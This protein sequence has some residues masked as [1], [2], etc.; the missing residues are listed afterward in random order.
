MRT[1]G[2]RRPRRDE[3]GKVI[4]LKESPVCAVT[5]EE[6][7][8]AF[9]SD[10]DKRLVVSLERGDRIVLRPAR[11]ARPVEITA[12]DLYRHLLLCKANHAQLERARAR[13]A[14][15]ALRLARERQSRAEKALFRQ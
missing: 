2:H 1:F 10:H 5:L 4:E 8:H 3:S 7:G 6:L 11:T 9:G 12:K 13:K 14:A 15:K